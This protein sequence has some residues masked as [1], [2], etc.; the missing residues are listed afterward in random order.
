MLEYVSPIQKAS[1]LKKEQTVEKNYSVTSA[2]CEF[3]Y[4]VCSVV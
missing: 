1:S 4:L 2:I 3:G